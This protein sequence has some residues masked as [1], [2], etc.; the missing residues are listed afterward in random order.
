MKTMIEKEKL[1][2]E[3]ELVSQED[4]YCYRIRAFLEWQESMDCN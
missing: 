4:D 2:G 3:D 1:D